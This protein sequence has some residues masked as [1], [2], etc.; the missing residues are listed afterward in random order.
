MHILQI[1][2]VASLATSTAAASAKKKKTADWNKINMDEIEET[3]KNG[4]EEEEL[5][6]E[7]DHIMRIAAKKQQMTGIDFDRPETLQ[8]YTIITR[9]LSIL[10]S[11]G[12]LRIP[13][14]LI[15]RAQ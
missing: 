10:T 6:H 9:R 3:W 1:L 13:L 12:W 2:L 5:E 8:K 11:I 4:D 7:M 15:P 14:E